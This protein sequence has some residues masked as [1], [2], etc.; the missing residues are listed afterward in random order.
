MSQARIF[1]GAIYNN[2]AFKALMNSLYNPLDNMK[3]SVATL[4]ASNQIDIATMEYGQYQPILAAPDGWPK[5]GG[6]AWLREMGRARIDLAAQPNDVALDGVVP[7]TKCGLLDASL[8]KCFNSDPPI[9]ININVQEHKQDEPMANTH[10]V[11]LEW[12]YGDGQ[13]KAPTLFNFTMV[14]P[15]RPAG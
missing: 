14:C 10:E 6:T 4:K 2:P 7:L 12:V 3:Q 13:D 15:Y 9:C 5:G 8:R 11:R 1:G